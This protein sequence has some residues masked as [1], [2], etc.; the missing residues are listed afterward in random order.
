M[1]HLL[2]QK[3]FD[4]KSSSSSYSGH[5]RDSIVRVFVFKSVTVAETQESGVSLVKISEVKTVC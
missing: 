3:L 5:N 2:G 4:D 1:W